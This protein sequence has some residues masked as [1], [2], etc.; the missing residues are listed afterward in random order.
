MAIPRRPSSSANLR[1]VPGR[2]S[3]ATE[4]DIWKLTVNTVYQDYLRGNR[5]LVTVLKDSKPAIGRISGSPPGRLTVWRD[6]RR[7]RVRFHQP[8]VPALEIT[9]QLFIFLPAHVVRPHH[10][11]AI[12]ISRVIH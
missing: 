2:R 5:E 12:D 6:F 9:D 11:G 7:F 1:T 4:P 3:S 10:F 8:G